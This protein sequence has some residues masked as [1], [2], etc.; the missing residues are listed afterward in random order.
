MPHPRIAK[1]RPA[2]YHQS[3][4]TFPEE[5]LRQLLRGLI[6]AERDGYHGLDSNLLISEP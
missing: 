6:T 1:Q 3:R 2:R 5:E 4:A